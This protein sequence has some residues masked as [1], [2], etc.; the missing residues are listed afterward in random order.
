VRH[1]PNRQQLVFGRAREVEQPLLFTGHG[2]PRS[3]R[4]DAP[5][6]KSRSGSPAG[7]NG[8]PAC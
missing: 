5:E 4:C 2:V 3:V 6:A 1:Q 8:N 7:C